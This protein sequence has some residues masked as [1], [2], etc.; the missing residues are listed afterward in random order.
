MPEVTTSKIELE[1]IEQRAI[2]SGEVI[3]EESSSF[4][5]SSETWY[6]VDSLKI[7]TDIPKDT[8]AFCTFNA[9][10][11]HDSDGIELQ[12]RFVINNN[13]YSPISTTT[14]ETIDDE[15]NYFPIA[16]IFLKTNL[17]DGINSFEIEVKT[18]Q[19]TSEL[20]VTNGSHVIAIMKR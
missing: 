7:E 14:I 16:N 18:I 4:P 12:Q 5:W 1:E 10:I 17:P 3:L 20:T 8:A 6:K 2:A 15:A 13:T 19:S 11:N 9:S